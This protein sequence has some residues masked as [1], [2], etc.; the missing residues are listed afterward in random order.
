MPTFAFNAHLDNNNNVALHAIVHN[1]KLDLKVQ[2][3]YN[4]PT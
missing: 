2:K 3:R 1:G 4:K